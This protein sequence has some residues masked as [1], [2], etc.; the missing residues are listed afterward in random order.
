M[1]R[2]RIEWQPPS[3]RIISNDMERIVIFGVPIRVWIGLPCFTRASLVGCRFLAFLFSDFWGAMV[4]GSCGL[5]GSLS[6]R[7]ISWFA[8]RKK[9]KKERKKEKKKKNVRRPLYGGP[10]AKRIEPDCS[11]VAALKRTTAQRDRKNSYRQCST[12]LNSRKKIP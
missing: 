4:K 2:L 1:A 6:E 11:Q 9:E 5:G 3:L 12:P 7:R 10:R 8:R